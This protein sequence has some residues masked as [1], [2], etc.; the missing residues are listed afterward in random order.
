MESKLKG[1]VVQL[2][3]SISWTVPSMQQSRMKSYKISHQSSNRKA[4]CAY[5]YIK[6]KNKHP[7]MTNSTRTD[8]TF[9]GAWCD[10]MGAKH[11]SCH[12]TAP[13]DKQLNSAS[14]L[15]PPPHINEEQFSP[16]K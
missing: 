3:T 6:T 5:Q 14:N 4:I 7:K 13:A 9:T 8:V 2:T 1:T 16:R 15:S 12:S 11:Y 10:R